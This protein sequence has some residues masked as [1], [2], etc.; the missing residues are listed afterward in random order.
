MVQ[1]QDYIHYPGESGLTIY[2]YVHY[3]GATTTG[4]ASIGNNIMYVRPWF[5][6]GDLPM[7]I[8]SI[9][10]KVTTSGSAVVAIGIY[11]SKSER[12][13]YPGNLLLDVTAGGYIQYSSVGHQTKPASITF[14]AGKM[15]WV[16]TRTSGGV[17]Q[18]R[19]A[20]NGVTPTV[21]AG[22]LGATNGVSDVGGNSALSI[23]YAFS[24]SMPAQFPTGSTLVRGYNESAI[25]AIFFIPAAPT[26]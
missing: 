24:A 8:E 21:P 9:G 23:A 19:C 6:A 14:E 4:N 12:N 22:V 20:F 1:P 5:P 13:I 26:P 18:H 3:D 11:E 7:T 17:G 2:N 25:P 10:I 16:A 15:Y